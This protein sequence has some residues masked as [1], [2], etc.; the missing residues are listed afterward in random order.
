MKTYKTI[1]FLALLLATIALPVA[2][3]DNSALS[4]GYI[5]VTFDDGRDGTLTYAAQSLQQDRL[6]ATMFIYDE[7]LGENWQGFLN[8]EG[9]LKL[10]NAYG[11]QFE[12]H[13]ETHPDMNHL[14]AIQLNTE[15]KTSR[16]V[17]QVDGFQPIASFAY[18]YDTGWDNASVLSPVKANY[19]AARRADA[20]GNTPVTYDRTRQ[21]GPIACNVCPPDRYQLEGNVVVNQTSI[22]TLTGYLDQAIANHTVLILVFH[23]IVAENP[24]QYEYTSHDFKNAM[25]YASQKIQAGVLESLYFSEAV[26]L[27][28]GISSFPP[29]CFLVCLTNFYTNIVWLG[30]SFGVVWAIVLVRWN[31]RKQPDPKPNLAPQLQ[32]L[33]SL[34]VFEVLTH[35]RTN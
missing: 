31:R 29:S 11:W 17:L 30:A 15:I 3:A 4:K 22:S 34:F 1:L 9:A 19:V 24:G 7:S 16:S 18:P 12:G 2:T 32:S 25:D 28:F 27:L 8:M 21:L 13:S 33:D 14:A 23:Q 5:V 35:A 20:F 26:Q 10:K 6:K